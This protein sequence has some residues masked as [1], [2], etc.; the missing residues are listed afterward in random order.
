MFNPIELA[1]AGLKKYVLDNN[2][3]FSLRDVRHLVY[4]WMTSLSRATAM[5]YINEA[6]KVEDIFKPSDRFTEEIEEQLVNEEEE[7]DSVLEEV[8]D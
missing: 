1:W 4:K 7:V 5:G 8:D 2:V 3:N 6:R